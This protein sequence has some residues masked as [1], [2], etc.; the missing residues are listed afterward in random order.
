MAKK[1]GFRLS[2][3]GPDLKSAPTNNYKLKEKKT[4]PLPTPTPNK[5]RQTKRC[6]GLFEQPLDLKSA[7]TNN[8]KIK[9]HNI[10]KFAN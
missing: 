8:N 6:I 1:L 3:R 7:P 5:E 2:K 10:T 9:D 4:I